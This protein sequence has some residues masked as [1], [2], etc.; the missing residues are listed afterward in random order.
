[1]K[2]E[3]VLIHEPYNKLKGFA[4]EKGIKYADF[5]KLLGVTITTISMKIN[6]YSDFYLNEQKLL[7]KHYGISDDF[8]S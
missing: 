4:V 5:A 1:M 7:K 2:K 8:F 3:K 6:G